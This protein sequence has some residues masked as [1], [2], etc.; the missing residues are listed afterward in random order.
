MRT[1]NFGISA[2]LGL[3]LLAGCSHD[4]PMQHID[5][6][7]LVRLNEQQMRP[8]DDARIE[9]GRARDNV[10]RSKAAVQDA[11]A[12]IDIAKA[13]RDVAVAQ[14]K[15]S[16]AELD[17]LIQQKADLKDIDHSKQ[18]YLMSEQRVQAVDRK[19]D[20]LNRSIGIAQLEENVAAQHA[21]VAGEAVERSKFQALQAANSNEIRGMNAA[22]I[23]QKLAEA[24]AKEAQLRKEAADKRVELVESYNKWQELD[25]KV[26]T[27]PLP[28]PAQ[29]TAPN[30]PSQP[31]TH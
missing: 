22:V 18:D 1:A 30:M 13:E 20:Y 14:Q 11:R 31:T 4:K 16:K 23:D 26:R 24:Q 25:A 19:L 29:P 15:R 12:K 28:L 7:A 9:E 6:G 27:A 2:I 3:G 5:N 8:V 21:V 10:A 17:L